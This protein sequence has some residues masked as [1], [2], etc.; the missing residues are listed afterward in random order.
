MDTTTNYKQCLLFFN[1]EEFLYCLQ[2]FCNTHIACQI[3]NIISAPFLVFGFS[4]IYSTI[5][6]NDKPPHDIFVGIGYTKLKSNNGTV[7]YT[8]RNTSLSIKK[9]SDICKF[10]NIKYTIVCNFRR[11]IDFAFGLW[12]FLN[13]QLMSLHPQ[14]TG[15]SIRKQFFKFLHR[16]NRIVFPKFIFGISRPCFTIHKLTSYNDLFF[17]NDID[18]KDFL[19]SVIRKGRC[20]RFLSFEQA[21]LEVAYGKFDVLS[22]CMGRDANLFPLLDKG[23]GMHIHIHGCWPELLWWSL[24]FNSSSYSGDSSYHQVGLK[25]ILS[26]EFMVTK[27][28]KLHF[29]ACLMFLRYSKN[30]ITAFG[31][32]IQRLT[33]NI[34][35]LFIDL[36]FALDCFN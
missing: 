26:L 16:I 12:S 31:K 32:A 28:L 2:E 35:C 13:F 18:V 33:K 10:S 6:L 3:P 5:A 7:A 8:G 29:V 9:S 27:V 4:G 21:S 25:F 1:N 22:S 11:A 20:S 17:K 30:I 19:I 14:G 23:E 36:E 24:A 34:Y 15:A